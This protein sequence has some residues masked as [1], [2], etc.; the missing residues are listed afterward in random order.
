LSTY[1]PNMSG[2]SFLKCFEV[3]FL[4]NLETK[5]IHEIWREILRSRVDDRNRDTFEC[6]I[7]GLFVVWIPLGY[8]IWNYNFWLIQNFRDFLLKCKQKDECN[9]GHAE[10]PSWI[11]DLFNL[12]PS[13][14][15]HLSYNYF[16]FSLN[17]EKLI[18]GNTNL[19]EKNTNWFRN[20]I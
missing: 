17:R 12:I 2:F 13:I 7:C 4:N 16:N 20:L 19:F 11:V 6:L 3:L 9:L 8:L 5:Q 15:K 18:S 1:F 14:F 10:A